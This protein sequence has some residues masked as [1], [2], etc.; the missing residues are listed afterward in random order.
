MEESGKNDRCWI[1]LNPALFGRSSFPVQ[2][3]LFT[4][5]VT[6]CFYSARHFRDYSMALATGTEQ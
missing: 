6:H 2:V 4:D 5:P 3:S 1:T